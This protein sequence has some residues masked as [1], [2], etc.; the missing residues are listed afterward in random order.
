MDPV[1]SEKSTLESLLYFT[2]VEY[3]YNYTGWWYNDSIPHCQWFGITCNKDGLVTKIE[4]RNN[5][6]T[7][8]LSPIYD[9]ILSLVGAFKELKKLVLAENKLT[10]DLSSSYIPTFLQLEHIDI[11]N[12]AFTGHVD[13]TFRSSTSY[14]NFSHNCFSGVSFKR[15]NAAYETLKIVDLSNNNISQDASKL[16][17]NIP[18]NIGKLFLSSN[19]IK[20]NLPDPFP[21][22]HLTLFNMSDNSVDGYLP[23]FPGS[24]PLLREIDLSNQKRANGGGL[25]GTIWTEVFRLVDLTVL[26]LAGNSLSGEIP[27]TIGNLAKLKVLNLS[28]NGLGKK[29]PLELGRLRGRCYVRID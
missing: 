4:L 28:S 23:D 15:F 11:S 17:N 26:N 2:G 14:V 25:V 16:F 10:G 24:A 21:L 1:A 7:G 29:I 8:G 9:V 27:T 12:N 20:G 13:M 19:A 22:E 5:N 3:W 6:L 18:P